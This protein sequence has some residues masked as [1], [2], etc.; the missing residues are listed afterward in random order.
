MYKVLNTCFNN[1][2]NCTLIIVGFEK[3]SQIKAG[4]IS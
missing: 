4:N 2:I 1:Y 3:Q